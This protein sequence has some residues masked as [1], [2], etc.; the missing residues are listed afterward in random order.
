M[1]FGGYD[2]L[3]KHNNYQE[4]NQSEWPCGLQEDPVL[5]QSHPLTQVCPLSL[6]KVEESCRTSEQTHIWKVRRL[7]P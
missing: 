6:T 3:D 4:Y 2:R 1:G 5:N 7:G